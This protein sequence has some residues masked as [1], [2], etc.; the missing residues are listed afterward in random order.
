MSLYKQTIKL[1]PSYIALTKPGI[2][3]LLLVTT[4]PAMILA[5]NQFPDF[6]LV[7]YTLIGGTLAAG[8]AN[9]MNHYFDRDIDKIMIRTSN[10][11][12]PNNI[13]P[14]S[15][16]LILGILLSTIAIIF[17]YYTV[18]PLATFITFLSIFFYVV[19]YTS[20]L[21]R[22][23]VQNI[24]IGGAA[25]STPPMIG[26][27]AVTNEISIESI[28]LFL[29]VF[30]WTPAHFWALSLL[31]EADYSK[32]NVPML[33]VVVGKQQAC[34][35]ILLYSLALIC[36]SIIFG[37]IA[38]TS[39]IY[40]SIAMPINILLLKYSIVLLKEYSDQKARKLFLFSIAYLVFLFGGMAVDVLLSNLLFN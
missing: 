34:K 19:I 36:I 27:I 6:K 33:P 18:N 37:I 12:L 20:Y 5:A 40:F 13:F 7:C 21:K 29:I 14:D 28:M 11:P 8:G 32:A 10:R 15:H 17:L 23:T 9:S 35:M 2:I 16:A 4:L 25:G 39:W 24:V 38:Q 3:W 1:I 31:K 22:R 30:Y 26:W